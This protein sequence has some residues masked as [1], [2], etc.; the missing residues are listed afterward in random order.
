MAEGSALNPQA[1]ALLQLIDSL[2]QPPMHTMTPTAAREF[3]AQ[4]RFHS[5][6]A[7]PMVQEAHDFSLQGPGGP[8]RM[9]RYRPV[10]APAGPLPALLYL[11]GGGWT[12]GDLDTHDVLC[13]QLCNA[14]RCAVYSVD[15]RMGPEHRFPA[16]V[17]DTLAALGWLRGA[18]REEGVDAERIAIG[19][20]SAGGNLAAVASI[21]AR[22]ETAPPLRLQLLI[23]PATDQRAVSDSHRRNGEGYLLTAELMR[24]FRENY[25]ASEAEYHDWRASPLLAPDVTGVAPAVVLVAGFDPLVDEGRAYADKL[26]AAGIPVERL[27]FEGQIHGFITMGRVIDDANRA[28]EACADSL[29]RAFG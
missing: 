27:V 22:S 25:H 8:I 20:D 1:A 9:R 19:G 14:A 6:P 23:Y 7:P 11:H 29:R 15:Y 2:G 12:I 24:W 13:R 28:I 10:D 4:R 21:A 18:A 16:A 3:Y 17:D 5:Q 26:E